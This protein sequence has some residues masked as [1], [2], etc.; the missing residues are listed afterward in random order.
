MVPMLTSKRDAAKQDAVLLAAV[1]LA[2]SALE[3]VA[4]PGT[5]GAHSGMEMLGERLAM[6]WFECLSPGY[7]GWRWGVSVARVPRAKVATVCETNLL[8]GPEAV[9]APEWLPYAD[10]LAPGDL[11]PGDV[12]PRRSDDPNL[13]AGFEA[14]GDEDVD[15]LAFFEL[16][17][18]R[19]RVLSPEGR[20]AAATRW[21]DGESG[22][23]AEIALKATARCS[24]CGYFVPMAGALR[25]V[26][27]VCANEW[28]P[29][30]GRVVS[31]DHGCGA[32]SETD[33]DQ[34]E[35]TPIGEPIVDELAVDVEQ[36]LPS[37]G[38]AMPPA[39]PTGE[40]EGGLAPEAVHSIEGE[41][42]AAETEDTAEDTRERD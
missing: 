13:E 1:D 17:L 6:H 30:D 32:H 2:R 39:D 29:S 18:G 38:D 7:H 31:L 14:T 4:E 27:G 15:Q 42:P 11:G 37:G 23:N 36:V 20:D 35:P 9:L 16:G 8:P 28:S 22:P 24:T 34:P 19:P 26:F 33:I 25:A 41:A 40:G 10:R 21:Y 5:V 12:L 3:E